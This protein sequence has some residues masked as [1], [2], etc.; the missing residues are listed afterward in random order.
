MSNHYKIKYIWLPS[1]RFECELCKAK[2]KRYEFY[3]PG[4][5]WIENPFIVHNLCDICFKILRELYQ[6]E[7]VLLF[8]H[9]KNNPTLKTF[10]LTEFY[11]ERDC[12][13]YRAKRNKSYFQKKELYEKELGAKIFRVRS[14][15]YFYLIRNYCDDDVVVLVVMMLLNVH[16][17]I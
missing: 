11:D 8:E 12:I 13:I 6:N 3:E 4:I 7:T 14:P 9:K 2:A 17:C 1:Y 10:Q 16:N 15:L 5:W